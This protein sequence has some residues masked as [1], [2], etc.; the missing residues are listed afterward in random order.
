ML[1]TRIKTI[2][3]R[4]KLFN[5]QIDHETL[6]GKICSCSGA[7]SGKVVKWGHSYTGKTNVKMRSIVYV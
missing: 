3:I 4:A 7:F 2:K 1:L 6:L 5:V